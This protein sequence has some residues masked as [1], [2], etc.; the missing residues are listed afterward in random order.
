MIGRGPELQRLR[1]L[2]AS[3]R[4]EVAVVAGEAGVGKTRLISEL[5]AGLPDTTVILR[6]EAQPGSLGR[7]YELLLDALAGQPV[8][9]DRLAGLTDPRRPSADRAQSAVELVESLIGA[10]PAVLVFEDLHWADA[11]STALLEQLADRSGQRLLIGTYRPAEVTR[12]QPVDALLARLDRRYAVTH[13]WLDRLTPDETS[14]LLAAARGTA[15]TYRTVMALHQRTGGNPFFLEEL[16]RAHEGSDLEQLGELPLPWSLAEVLRQ[17]LADLDPQCRRIIEAAAVLGQ[18]IPFDLLATVTGTG[19]QELIVALRDLVA[20]GVLTESGEDEFSFRHALLREVL[21]G[22]LLGRERRRLHEAALDALLGSGAAGEG[23]LRSGDAALVAH[24][25]QAARR[26]E[27]MVLAARLGSE[28]YLSTGSVYQALQLAELGLEQAA[29]DPQLLGTAAHA[30]WLA[31]LLDDAVGYARRWR[32]RSGDAE[33]EMRAL[34]LLFRLAW[35]SDDEAGARTL[36]REIE[37]LVDELPVGELCGRALATLAQSSMLRRERDEALRHADRALALAGTHQLPV[38]R[39]AALVEKGSV[40]IEAQHSAAAGRQ[41]LHEAA[42][43][44]ERLGEWFLAARALN[45]VAFNPTSGSHREQAEVLERMRRDAI[46]AGSDQFAVAAYYQG[47][48]WLEME[49]GDLPAARQALQDGTRRAEQYARRG[50][51]SDYH[52]P[53]LAGLALEAGDLAQARMVVKQL[54]CAARPPS[55]ATAGLTFHL[56]CRSGDRERAAAILPVLLDELRASPGSAS[57]DLAHDL[58]SAALAGGVPLAQVEELAKVAGG[59]RSQPGWQALVAAQL[60]E[61]AGDPA[62]ALPGYRT[63]AVDTELTLAARGTAATGAASCLLALDRPEE[64][65][66]QVAEASQLLHRWSGW[67]VAQLVAVRERAGLAGPEGSVTGLEALTPREREV[68]QLIADGLTNA[69]LARRLYISPR[70]AAVHVSNILRKLEVESRTEVAGRL[71]PAGAA[72]PTPAP[73][74][75]AGHDQPRLMPQVAGA[76]R[77]H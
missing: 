33:E 1:R 19:E 40:L 64:A 51:T 30:A 18:R 15:P 46:R 38:T 68:A 29:H 16:L 26:Y 44:A 62:G 2:G 28:R 67:R 74:P 61:A 12:R 56:A 50:R 9:A 53:G 45:N 41:M 63:A 52:A 73:R 25:A 59:D 48:A 8:P 6:G 43:E 31:G 10:G 21:T 7:P 57:G 14:A 22:S 39:V 76:V 58:V 36:T 27:D 3:P 75:G 17:Q 34:M 72:Q 11:E 54:G 55:P 60:A 49:A 69:A 24:H 42:D 70:T 71:R 13:L 47:L 65:A 32:D 77:P 37:L 66:Q 5:L 23:C 35:E 4:V 20:R